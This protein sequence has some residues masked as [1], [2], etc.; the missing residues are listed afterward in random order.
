ML[1][2]NLKESKKYALIAAGIIVLVLGLVVYGIITSKRSSQVA[3][4]RQELIL[5]LPYLTTD[6]SVVY[7]ENKNQIYVNVIKPPYEENRAKALDW[8]KSQGADPNKLNIVYTP[9][10]KFK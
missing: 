7:S 8:L 4:T 6:Y 2:A 1:P 9:Q 5:N 10:N 3:K